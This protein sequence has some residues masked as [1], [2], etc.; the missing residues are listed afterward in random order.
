MAAHDNL[1][2]QQFFHG[3]STEGLTE[4]TPRGA[5][6][7]FH[8]DHPGTH[9]FA[10]TSESDAWDYAEKAWNHADKGIPR[11]YRVEP[12][13]EVE[14]DPHYQNT[15]GTWHRSKHGFRV[16]GEVPMPEHMGPA[17]DWR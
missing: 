17:E 13:G 3:S 6:R 14:K 8:S 16:V 2:P 1:S 5:Q 12:K 11:V 15:E 4:I 7:Y 10:T 9:A